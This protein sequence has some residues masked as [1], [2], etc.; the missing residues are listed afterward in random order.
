MASR[1]KSNLIVL[2]NQFDY[3]NAYQLADSKNRE[4]IQQKKSLFSHQIEFE[5]HI[6]TTMTMKG[7]ASS[8]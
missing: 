4:M 3:H 6:E 5:F 8:R 1:V 2:M 7:S